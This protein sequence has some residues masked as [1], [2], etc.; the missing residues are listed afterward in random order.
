[1]KKEIE[2]KKLVFN[3]LLTESDE[4]NL[5]FKKHLDDLA[6]LRYNL[7][8]CV[9]LKVSH[10]LSLLQSGEEARDTG[11]SWVIIS[12]WS[13]GYSVNLK[14]FNKMLDHRNRL[15]LVDKACLEVKIA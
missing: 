14:E 15:F 12:L 1:V 10:L 8:N 7:G 4:L 13:L 3:K 2:I 6:N 9:K 5:K 11:L